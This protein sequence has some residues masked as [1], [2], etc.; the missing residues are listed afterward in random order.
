MLIVLK[1]MSPDHSRR[2]AARRHPTDSCYNPA[3]QWL[4]WYF[5]YTAQELL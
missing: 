1:N 5:A 2:N 4:L 3:S